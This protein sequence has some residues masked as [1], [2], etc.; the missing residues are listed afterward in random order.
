MQVEI[1]FRRYVTGLY[2]K[3]KEDDGFEAC[4][5]GSITDSFRQ[6]TVEPLSNRHDRWNELMQA[7]W[8][9]AVGLKQ[10][11]RARLIYKN[12]PTRKIADSSSPARP[13]SD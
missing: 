2:V 4:R 9:H 1:M 7:S 13:D 5:A 11:M 8:Q 10:P 6:G 3:P 12:T